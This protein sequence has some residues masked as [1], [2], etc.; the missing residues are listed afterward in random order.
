MINTI[1]SG[2]TNASIS[3][4]NFLLTP[5]YYLIDH[6]DLGNVN[7]SD[8]VTSFNS[9]VSTATTYV[10]WLVDA[11]GIPR[12]LLIV[13]F[14]ILGQCILLRFQMYTLKLVLKWWD[15]IIA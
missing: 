12:P 15:R 9:F 13:I 3:V 1:I 7:L 6:I 10:S 2:L 5:I 4:I 11:L 14:A 8:M